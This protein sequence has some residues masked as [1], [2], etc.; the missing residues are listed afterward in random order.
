MGI[1][2]GGLFLR[3][4]LSRVRTS[5][6]IHAGK[7]RSAKKKNTSR[8]CS[9]YRQR[10]ETLRILR[11]ANTYSEYLSGEIWKTIRESVLERDEYKCVC[12]GSDACQVHHTRYNAA[13]L[14]G[15]TLEHLFSVCRE[16]H[17]KIEFRKGG[18]KRPMQEALWRFKKMIGRSKPEIQ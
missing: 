12:C 17:I 11:L 14:I 8:D 4:R 18:A 16:C 7:R 6:A 9:D 2:K 1:W 13:T 10:N 3:P 5:E 15:K